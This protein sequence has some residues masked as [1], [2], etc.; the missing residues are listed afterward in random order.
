MG[1]NI[2][3]LTKKDNFFVM[4]HVYVYN[5][6]QKV[7]QKLLHTSKSVKVLSFLQYKNNN[8]KRL[9]KTYKQ[10]TIKILTM[11]NQ[12]KKNHLCPMAENLLD[13]LLHNPYF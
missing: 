8:N 12:E 2:E 1:Y 13:C 10:S 4:L 7:F 3:I 11:A 5:S 6:L 9:L